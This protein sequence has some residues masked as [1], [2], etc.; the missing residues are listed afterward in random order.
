[1]FSILLYGSLTSS[2]SECAA[3]NAA[4][5]I[6]L[7]WESVRRPIAIV[8]PTGTARATTNFQSSERTC[9]NAAFIACPLRQ[10]CAIETWRRIAMGS[11][12]LPLQT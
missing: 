3:K 11:R 1:M 2:L 8:T 4:S 9:E 6:F 5:A 7:F 12:T 10:A